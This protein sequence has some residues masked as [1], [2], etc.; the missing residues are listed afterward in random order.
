MGRLSANGA[1]A[2]AATGFEAGG[3]DVDSTFRTL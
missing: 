2:L 1:L 3:Y